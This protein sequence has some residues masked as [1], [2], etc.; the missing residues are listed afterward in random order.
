MIRISLK[1]IKST[2]K[3]KR[4]PDDE[5][6]YQQ[7]TEKELLIKLVKS[8]YQ[9]KSALKNISGWVTFFG[10]ITVL[11]ILLLAFSTLLGY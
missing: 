2:M 1:S 3:K 6:I 11:S 8:N 7:Y 9:Q 4:I 10:I 5:I